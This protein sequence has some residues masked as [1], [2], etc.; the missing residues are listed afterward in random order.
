MTVHLDDIR[1]NDLLCFDLYTFIS[2]ILNCFVD[3]CRT[4][5]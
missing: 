2:V 5:T 4:G 1:G 3:L